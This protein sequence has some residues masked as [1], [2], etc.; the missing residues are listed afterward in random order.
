M[1]VR[2]HVVFMDVLIM[3]AG[4]GDQNSGDCDLVIVV[5]GGDWTVTLTLPPPPGAAPDALTRRRGATPA[6]GCG[7]IGMGVVEL[8]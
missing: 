1:S 2:E 7:T 6:S 3:S 8:L 4:A 5:G